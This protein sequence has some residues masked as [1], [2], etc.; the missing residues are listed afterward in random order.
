MEIKSESEVSDNELQD[1]PLLLV[2]MH[3]TNRSILRIQS[4]LPIDFVNNNIRIDN[5]LANQK[6]DVVILSGYPNPLNRRSPLFFLT[7][8]DA[9][10]VAQQLQHPGYRFLRSGEFSVIRAGRTVVLG[11]FEQTTQGAAWTV[12]VNRTRNYA[13]RETVTIE[14]SHYL[15]DYSGDELSRQKVALLA[16]KQEKRMV[17]ALARLDRADTAPVLPRIHYYLYDTLEDKGLITGNTDLSHFD[18]STW[19]VHAV[20]N[21]NLRGTDF[22]SDANLLALKV[23]GTTQSK[24]LRDGLAIALSDHW[25]RQGYEY[26]AKKIFDADQADALVEILDSNIYQKKSYLFTRPLAGSFVSFLLT[27]YGMAT[28][29]ALYKA[30]PASGLPAIDLPDFTL[31]NLAQGWREALC[32]LQIDAT[33]VAEPSRQPV[34]QKG[35]CYAHEGY[36]IHNG[37]LSRESARSL[38][39]LGSLGVDW[40]SITPFGYLEKK[41]QP[42]YFRFSQGAGSE[43]DESVL[44][45][46]YAAR[47]AGIRTLLKPHVLMAGGDFGWPGDI[48]MKNAADWRAF[49]SYYSIWIRHYAL[50][51]EMYKMDMFCI[52]VEL[53]H[54]TDGHAKEWRRLIRNVRQIYHGPIVYA[55]NWWQ[56]FEQIEFWDE[57]DYIGLNC[58]YPLSKDDKVTLEKLKTG[59]EKFLPAIERVARRYRKPLIMTEVGFTSTEQNW[60]HPHER[61]RG[62]PVS[63]DD[64]ALCYRAIFESFWDKK[65]FAGFYW[66]KWPTYL[67]YG[68]QDHSGFTPNGKPAEKVVAEWYSKTPRSH[69]GI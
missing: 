28:F 48:K 62:A 50:L 26:W 64:Q 56:E 44:A 54:A 32:K 69:P 34:F 8:P 16:A 5:F 24:A 13:D 52:G 31:I 20:F 19:S 36:Q 9:N 47:K 12:D 59:V 1:L 38:T 11:L 2:G 53:L 22:F 35:F 7:G 37:Y 29:S 42:D 46:F 65:W 67:D 14:T 55:A 25:G 3:F 58:Y 51:A 68:G 63:L 43:N 15:F 45:A 66:W 4:Q 41:N 10:A 21:D 23:L 60:K 57:L 39:K 61:R 17:A 40:V 18:S 49:F 27:K 6:S 33:V 30:W